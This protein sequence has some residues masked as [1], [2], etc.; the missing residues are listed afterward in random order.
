M[1]GTR[2]ACGRGSSMRSASRRRTSR[3]SRNSGS[4]ASIQPSMA[5]TDRASPS[6]C[7][8]TGSTAPTRTAR[9]DASGARL[10]GGSDAPVEE[11]GPARRHRATRC[12]AR[13]APAT[14]ALDAAQAALEALTVT[15]AWLAG[16]EDRRGRLAPGLARRPR[17]SSTAT[18]STTCATRRSSTPIL[19]RPQYGG[20]MSTLAATEIA[21][22]VG[23]RPRTDAPGGA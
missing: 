6:S 10:A 3:A 12:C 4:T 2:A 17:R 23:G 21:S 11:I 15:P 1:R 19:R 13:V 14:E 8:P 9:C 20:R 22:I 7:G 18:R 16:D 5:V